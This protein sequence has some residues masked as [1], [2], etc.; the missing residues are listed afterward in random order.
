MDGTMKEINLDLVYLHNLTV[1]ISRVR[2]CSKFSQMF[3]EFNKT[4]VA[5][6][7]IRDMLLNKPISDIDVFYEG[8]L[9]DSKLQQYFTNI[10]PTGN[11]Y[12]DGF[13]VTH[14]IMHIDFPV[15]IQ[16]IQVKNIKNHI[17][18]FPSPMMRLSLDD[19]GISGMD[20]CFFSD[21]QVQEFCWDM[22]PDLW[23]FLKIKEKYSDWKHVFM[24]EDM[25]P[26]PALEAL[27]VD[28]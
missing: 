13:N 8:E 23:Y 4:V 9:D 21:A 1:L 20:T 15:P 26:E 17:G 19:T 14:T 11:T 6:G 27:D 3:G 25:N 12:P 18:T 22:K 24:E 2:V 5:G 16:L 10:K 28:F 7:A